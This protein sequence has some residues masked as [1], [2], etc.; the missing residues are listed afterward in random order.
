MSEFAERQ[1]I[2]VLRHQERLLNCHA[3]NVA[4]PA[5][6]RS[7]KSRG[8]VLWAIQR[9]HENAITGAVLAGMLVEPNSN[10]LN[11]VLV[12]DLVEVC[13][14]MA[15][16]YTHWKQERRF[17]LHFGD[18]LDFDL[19]L[20]SADRPEALVGVT[21]CFVAVDEAGVTRNAAEVF[22]R[23]MPR[24]SEPRAKVKQ[25][26]ATGTPEGF[27]QFYQF[28]EGKPP[29]GLEL[30]RARTWD[31][32][33]IDPA[34]YIA[35]SLSYLTDQDKLSYVEGLFIAKGGRVY[36]Y[37]EAQDHERECVAPMDGELVMCCD[38]GSTTS[39]FGLATIYRDVVQRRGLSDVVTERCHI[40]GE[41]V[42]R[43]TST[44]AQADDAQEAW[45]EAHGKQT[46]EYVRWSSFVGRIK[47]YCDSAPNARADREI[48]LDRGF[49]VISAGRNEGVQDRV[50]AVNNKLRNKLLFV[51][52]RGAPYIASCLRQQGYNSRGWPEK[53]HDDGSGDPGLD[54]GSDAVGYLVVHRW[55]ILAPRG[56]GEIHRHH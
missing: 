34:Y 39:V 44:L 27:G 54:H 13:G 9:S 53:G 33:F 30:I 45:V 29:P 23:A 40:W 4:M 18:G 47:A 19:Y 46:G 8:L 22:R 56:Q 36:S 17:R 42:G 3:P 6:Y 35:N 7:G 12:R 49:D 37:Y 24:I 15:I 5:G 41:V 26:L 31:N 14:E 25:F 32:P 21:V 16:P 50:H 20:R 51:D 48:L 55:P 52:P 10:L 43:R 28:A 1:G 38:F 2:K 11:D